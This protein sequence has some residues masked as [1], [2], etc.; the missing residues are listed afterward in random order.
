MSKRTLPEPPTRR[1]VRGTACVPCLFCGRTKA[2]KEDK[3]MNFQYINEK[4][5]DWEK[6]VYCSKICRGAWRSMNGDE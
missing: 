4:T 2:D 1:S 3:P 6:N 5:G